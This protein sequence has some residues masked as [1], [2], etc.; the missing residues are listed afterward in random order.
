M[1]FLGSKFLFIMLGL[2]VGT[3]ASSGVFYVIFL[4]LDPVHTT[5]GKLVGVLVG[6]IVVGGLVAFCIF[7]FTQSFAVPILSAVTGGIVVLMLTKT[8]NLG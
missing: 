8:F 4:M 1:T 3:V 6:S 7:K 5:T 2:I